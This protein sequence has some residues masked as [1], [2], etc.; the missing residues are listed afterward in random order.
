MTTTCTACGKSWGGLRAE[1]C[2]VCHETFSGT[3]AGDRHRTGDH[4]VFVGPDRR[5]CLT[6]DEMRDKGLEQNTKGI[7]T[8]GGDF[9]AAK[10]G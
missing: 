7:W 10:F 8:N 1:H 6:A 5:R 3:T 9:P 2:T 4:A